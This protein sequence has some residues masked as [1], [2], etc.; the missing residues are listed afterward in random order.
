MNDKEFELLKLAAKAV[1]LE[2]RREDD[3][4]IAAFKYDRRWIFWNPLTDFADSFKLACD[5]DMHLDLQWDTKVFAGWADDSGFNVVRENVAEGQDKYSQ[6]AIAIV[7]MAAKIG[8][9]K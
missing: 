1:N 3:G 5:L 2:I 9:T 8:A 4:K 6:A 7:K